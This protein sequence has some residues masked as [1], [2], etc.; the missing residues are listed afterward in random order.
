M[1]TLLFSPAESSW[2]MSFGTT[3]FRHLSKWAEKAD[4]YSGGSMSPSPVT[5]KLILCVDDTPYVLQM[6]DLFLTAVGY[7]TVLASNGRQAI[8]LASARRLDAVILDYEMPNLN[9][10]EVAQILKREHP[11]LPILMYSARQPQTDVSAAGVID[12]YVEK[13]HPQALVIELA[14]ILGDPTPVLVR[15]RFPRY[16]TSSALTLRFA[17]R[18]AQSDVTFRGTMKD[19]AEG[20]CGGEI[21]TKVVPGELV[22]LGF[23]VPECDLNLELH[24]RVRYCSAEAHG[25]EFV[26]LSAAQQQGLRRC[27]EA[28]ATS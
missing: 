1:G 5:G 16:A 19:L 23:G 27:L 26:D 4:D 11:Q 2:Y 17:E 24:A 13:E 12:A 7:R 14:H 21:D 6:L 28:L 8:N 18:D 10:L 20:G 25:F 22:A 3:H 15:R 9:G